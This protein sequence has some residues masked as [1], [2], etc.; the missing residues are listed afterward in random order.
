MLVQAPEGAEILSQAWL[1]GGVLA[2][3][4]S[5]GDVLLKQDDNVS[6]M[7]IAAGA[8]LTSIASFERGFVVGGTN[9]AM[10]FFEPSTPAAR[11]ARMTLK[12]KNRRLYLHE[13][14]SAISALPLAPGKP[15]CCWLACRLCHLP[16][17]PPPPLPSSC[18]Q[19]Y[20]MSS[21]MVLDNM[22]RC[23]RCIIMIDIRLR[24]LA[25]V[26]RSSLK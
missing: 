13:M 10:A 9:A 21:I 8:S 25:Q 3:S 5:T 1:K 12:Y 22:L 24:R 20:S 7:T 16:P 2:L 17:P 18:E 23:I 6:S 26:M 4:F 14:P 15:F 19:R 11:R